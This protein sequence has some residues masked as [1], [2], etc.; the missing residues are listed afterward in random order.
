MAVYEASSSDFLTEG[1][2]KRTAGVATGA[3]GTGDLIKPSSRANVIVR[4]F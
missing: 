4:L 3:A 2:K 1:I